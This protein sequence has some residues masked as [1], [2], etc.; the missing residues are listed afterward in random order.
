MLPNVIR[1]SSWA[2]NVLAS[3]NKFSRRRE[4]SMISVHTSFPASLYRFQPQRSSGLFNYKKGGD[5]ED[6]V[7]VSAD[8]LVYPRV[9]NDV[10]FSNGAVFMPNTF[11]M[12]EWV[13]TAYD[14]YIDG[15][16]DGQ[17]VPDTTILRVRK[18]TPIPSA[19][20]LFR[21]RSYRFSLQPSRPTN[22]NDLN[23]LLS[24]FYHQNA[25]F[26]NAEEWMDRNEYHNSIA[27]DAVGKWMC[28]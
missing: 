26:T 11:T 8:G 13:R 5:I 28:Q 20:T 10:P 16:E 25:T 19:L 2:R 24:D 17:S 1:N 3:Q 6:G 23:N 15:L 27:D 22:V 7:E 9:S 18:G 21:D 14:D 12:Q 4:L